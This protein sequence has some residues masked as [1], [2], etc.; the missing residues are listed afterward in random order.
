MIQRKQSLFLLL[1]ALMALIFL[2]GDYL[3]F[4]DISGGNYIL[5]FG[6]LHYY[7]G[8]KTGT[9]FLILPIIAIIIPVLS[10][11]IIFL[12]KNRILQIKLTKILLGFELIFILATIVISLSLIKQ[13]DITL[14]SW[15]KCLIPL[16]QLIFSVLALRSIRKDDEL[17]KSYDRIR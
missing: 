11:I 15:Y 17:V 7:N 8:E 14:N 12:Y 1:T 10:L 3:T 2:S 13:L 6:G 5:D 4:V 9:Y 16:F